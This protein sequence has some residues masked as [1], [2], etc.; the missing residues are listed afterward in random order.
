MINRIVMLIG[1]VVAITAGVLG[2]SRAAIKIRAVFSGLT[3]R[4]G[5]A[6][7]E[8]G[9][10]GGPIS[11]FVAGNLVLLQSIVVVIAFTAFVFISAPSPMTV[12]WLALLTGIIEI[13]LLIVARAGN[14]S[15]VESAA[16][17][18]GIDAALE[19]K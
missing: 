3:N 15:P 19:V 4:A 10:L 13:V 7:S 9:V 2:E 5:S 1:L 17:D 8:H 16:K 14:K 18:A 11:N 12:V 6:G